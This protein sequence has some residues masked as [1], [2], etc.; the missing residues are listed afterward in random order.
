MP[1]QEPELLSIYWQNGRTRARNM[2]IFHDLVI[3]ATDDPKTRDRSESVEQN[4]HFLPPRLSNIVVQYLAYIHPLMVMLPQLAR[5]LSNTLWDAEAVS[6][7][8]QD[9]YLF[10]LPGRRPKQ[11]RQRVSR[12]MVKSSAATLD[13]IPIS[14]TI[15]RHI[16]IAITKQ[17]LPAHIT[18]EQL[19]SLGVLGESIYTQQAEYQSAVY[20]QIYTINQ[21]SPKGLTTKQLEAFQHT[22]HA[23]Q[24]FIFNNIQE[25][26]L[27]PVHNASLSSHPMQDAPSGWARPGNNIPNN[28]NTVNKKAMSI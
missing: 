2:Y 10:Q 6:P 5:S 25:S 13:R 26:T 4:L 9:Q 21:N 1:T 22:S 19:Q 20:H 28:N 11:V 17:Y 27:D 18:P 15:Y 16:A 23:W 24:Q 14:T 12:A 7:Q 3:I 8:E